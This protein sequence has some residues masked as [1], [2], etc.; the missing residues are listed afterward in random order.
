[1]TRSS[2]TKTTLA[3]VAL[4]FFTFI[5]ANQTFAGKP[6][7]VGVNV[8]AARQVSMDKVDHSAWD[9]ALRKFVDKNG[10]VNYRAWH[11]SAGDVQA[12]DQ[13]LRT[14]STANPNVQTTRDGKLAFWI[15]AYNAVTVKGILREYPTTSIRNHTA[16]VVGYNVWKDLQLIV[17]G[18]P[19]SL[20]DI[21]HKVLR[22]MNEPRIHFA[23]VCASIGCPRLFNQAYVANKVQAQMETNAKDFFSRSQNFRHNGNRFEISAI[24]NWFKEDFGA[25]QKQR[26]E[27]IAKWLPTTAQATARGGRATV[28][29]LDY[30]WQLN[31][32]PKSPAGSGSRSSTGSGSRN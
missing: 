6:V 28:S 13:Y 7:Y 11:A 21:E 23:I 12:L 1:M 30:N 18:R 9:R 20:N 26:L 24:L 27:T 4:L 19:I 2:R 14:L 22:K 16:K 31:A 17:G 10:M 29:Y 3:I 8:P 15:N 5:A 25:N 32:Q